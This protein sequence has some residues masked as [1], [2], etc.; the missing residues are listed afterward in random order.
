MEVETQD[1]FRFVLALVFV[2]SLFGVLVLVARR[3][4]LGHRMATRSA[5]AKKRLS[6]VEVMGLDAKRRLVLLR[7]DETE[8]LVILGPHGETVIETAIA[9]AP[10]STF[11]DLVEAST[12][13]K[14]AS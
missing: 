5:N 7:R 14:P 3:Y 2:V 4:G 8:H 13:D 1:Y 12:G 10:A 6:L 9:A 11:A